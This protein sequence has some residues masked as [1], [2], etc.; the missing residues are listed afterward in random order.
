MIYEREGIAT[1]HDSTCISD[2]VSLY[3][4]SDN[5]SA[6]KDMCDALEAY[7]ILN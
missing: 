1:F 2:L 7:N 3:T 6:W 4:A 5:L